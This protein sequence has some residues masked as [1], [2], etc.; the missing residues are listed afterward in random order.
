[1]SLSSFTVRDLFEE[2]FNTCLRLGVPWLS[3]RVLDPRL[4]G[5]R[6]EPHKSHCIVSL[7]K[8]HYPLLSTG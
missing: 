3:I 5:C 6:F 2:V 8:T 4:R 7:S 1:M